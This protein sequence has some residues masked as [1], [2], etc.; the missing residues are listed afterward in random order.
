MAELV[1]SDKELVDKRSGIIEESSDYGLNAVDD[2]VIEGGAERGV[3]GILDLGA[4]DDGIVTLQGKLAF[5]G[6]RM[7]PFEAESGNNFVHGEAARARGILHH[8]WHWLLMSPPGEQS[9]PTDALVIGGGVSV[10]VADCAV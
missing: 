4:I 9:P 10:T 6:V 8:R 7:I 1:D 3:R 5:L 2:F